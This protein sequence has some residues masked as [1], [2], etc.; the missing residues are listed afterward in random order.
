MKMR[1]VCCLICLLIFAF[2]CLPVLA[3]SVQTEP[4]IGAWVLDRVYENASSEDR[5]V[6]DPESAA[7]VYAETAN[8]Y[9]LFADGSA[10]V[11]LQAEGE[12]FEQ[13]DLTW[14]I[15]EDSYIICNDIAVVQ[16]F[17][18]DPEDHVFHRYWKDS[19]PEATYHDLDF[20]YMRVPVGT[21]Q[22]QMVYET[23]GDEPVLLEPES[24]ASLYAESDDLYHFIA[25]GAAAVEYDGRMEEATW[26]LDDED[27]L[28]TFDVGG[29]MLFTYDPDQ[30]MLFRYWA[31]DDQ[32]ATYHSLVFVYLRYQ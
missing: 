20:V 5:F 11:L 10:Q 1:W 14:T 17:S 25:D 3:D 16:E 8:V 31:D 32:D 18:W 15:F 12:I 24:S 29:E 27:L 4:V 28:L 21:W 13:N 30:D 2:G 23:S 26:D 9:S 6:L 7:S 19:E 22:M